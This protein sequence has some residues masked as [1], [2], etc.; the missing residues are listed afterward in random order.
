M[1]RPVIMRG[2]KP[3]TII[4]H[5]WVC[6]G[7]KYNGK[8]WTEIANNQITTNITGQMGVAIYDNS[9][10]SAEALRAKLSANPITLVYELA[11]PIV[12]DI[13]D[14]ITP[15]NFIEVQ[16]GGSIISVNEYEYAVP[17]TMR[18]QKRS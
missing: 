5:A 10:T 8:W 13:T 16:G 12:T 1:G 15:D 4:G 6:D 7:Y 3:Q 2:N 17:N 11:E 14:L 18:Y 9:C